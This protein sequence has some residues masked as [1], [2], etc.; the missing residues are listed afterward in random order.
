M[1]N[2]PKS[3]LAP[4]ILCTAN[5]YYWDGNTVEYIKDTDSKHYYKLSTPTA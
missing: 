3:N 4:A 2:I 1:V 5:K